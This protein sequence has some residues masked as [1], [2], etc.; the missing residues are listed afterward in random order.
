MG[1]NGEKN[2]EPMIVSRQSQA[3]GIEVKLVNVEPKIEVI[4]PYRLP[5]EVRHPPRR[6]GPHQRNHSNPISLM[7]AILALLFSASLCSAQLIPPARLVDW[8]PGMSVGVSGGIDQYRKGRTHLLNVT[9]APYY[10]PNNGVGDAQPGIQAAVD[11]AASGDVIYMP[12][13]TYRVNNPIDI[14]Y[15]DNITLRGAGPSRTI[16]KYRASYGAAIQV[17][18]DSAYQWNFPNLA[19]TGR[20]IKGTT[21]LSVSP[22]TDIAVGVIAELSIS[23]SESALV[24]VVHVSGY[25]G[26]RRQKTRVI[27]KTA[28][29][30]TISP[31]LYFDMPASLSPRI[32]TTQGNQAEFVGVEDLAVDGTN[33]AT[34]RPLVLISQGFGC[35]LYNVEATVSPNYHIGV[36]DSVQCEVRHCKG[37]TRKTRGTNGAA[38]L[39]LSASACLIEDNIFGENFP[40]LEINNGSCGNVFAYNFIYDSSVQGVE[41]AA[42]DSNH[43]PHNS[44]NLYEGNF[45]PN[46]QCDGYFG[47][48]SEDTLFRNWF[49]GAIPDDATGWVLSLNRFTRNYSLVGNIFGNTLSGP[50]NPYSFGNPNMGNGDHIGKAQPS[51]GRWWADYRKRPGPEGFQELD[52]D[53]Q[54]TTILKGNYWA[55]TGGI[56]ASEALSEMLPNSLFRSSKPAYFGSLAWPPVSPISPFTPTVNN[57]NY[58]RIPAGYRYVT[59]TDPSPG[60]TP[61]PTPVP[62]PTPEPTPV[63][64]PEPPP[65]PTPTPIP[66]PT[67]SPTPIVEGAWHVHG[68]VIKVESGWQINLINDAPGNRTTNAFPIPSGVTENYPHPDP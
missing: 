23:N 34:P 18:G 40:V 49:H 35:W 66:V 41:G 26:L 67:P 6:N 30:I 11:A 37:R 51:V 33:S 24:P 3:P 53:V 28:S 19:I 9:L 2:P 16:I 36:W 42:I 43:G 32:A 56:P 57:V 29:T 1:R 46:L 54:A 10:A 39:M 20:P 44:H 68:T 8:T 17:G 63:P 62:T 47:S 25:N 58:S 60:P 14:G 15:K 27:A 52:L 4:N 5:V 31:G 22:T 59:G 61:K 64:T 21:V 13:G 12:A 48:A 45:S 7:K 50:G 55:G 65:V 38:F